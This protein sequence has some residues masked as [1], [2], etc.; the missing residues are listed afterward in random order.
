M[1]QLLKEEI[2]RKR[3][4]SI[5][6]L[7]AVLS[8]ITHID[9]SIDALLKAANPLLVS[10][11][12]EENKTIRDALDNIKEKQGFFEEAKKRVERKRKRFQ[13]GTINI[14]ICGLMK[15]GK[16]T[17][18]KQLTG[19]DF[20]PTMDEKCTAVSTA[21]FYE[22]TPSPSAELE[23]FTE[24]EYVERVIN[25]DLED[26]KLPKVTSLSEFARTTIPDSDAFHERDIVN[27]LKNLKAYRA[28]IEKKL[29]M[30]VQ[31]VND[32]SQLKQLIAYPSEK[33]NDTYAINRQNAIIS[34]IKSCK[35][36]CQ[37]PTGMS[38]LVILDT[39]GVDD[40]NP[41]VV[42]DTIR[43]LE[44]DTD[45]L[46]VMARP[47]NK[48][49]ITKDFEKM[50]MAFEGL[51]DE[52]SLN[53]KM[54]FVLNWHES[55][56]PDKS[57]VQVFQKKLIERGVPKRVFCE[58]VDCSKKDSISVV[59]NKINSQLEQKL[60]SQDNEVIKKFK[61][62]LTNTSNQIWQSLKSIEKTRVVDPA[63]IGDEA[64]K[65]FMRWFE[66][67][68]ETK[69]FIEKLRIGL[70][71]AVREFK[72]QNNTLESQKVKVKDVIKELHEKLKN[73]IPKDA[74]EIKRKG[75]EKGM[76]GAFELYLDE[77][78][79]IATDYIDKICVIGQEFAP[80]IQ[81]ILAKIFQDAGLNPIM[82]GATERDK[83]QSIIDQLPNGS[84]LSLICQRALNL[85]EQL[86]YIIRHKLRPIINLF[87]PF[88]WENNVAWKDFQ[89]AV[90]VLPKEELSKYIVPLDKFQWPHP[91][92]PK[93][94]TVLTD[95]VSGAMLLL[96]GNQ[97]SEIN[98]IA[99]DILEYFRLILGIKEEKDIR[100]TLLPLKAY[101]VPEIE[102]MM[103]SSENIR[104]FKVAV[105]SL[106]TLCN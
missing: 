3:Q 37:F 49:E 62:E 87:N 43:T 83:L 59:M 10:M 45:V 71:K 57:N 7:D 8:K 9:T 5:P 41:K 102:E 80:I 61:D 95:N 14:S 75:V 25:L 101:F 31:F 73:A 30:P 65:K 92:E 84:D 2:V 74:D 42:K 6:D 50:W 19:V 72:V 56:D 91:N 4:Q 99:I 67:D 96:I 36:F 64:T 35:I 1:A 40:T 94:F 20:L 24:K 88:A 89:S 68:G 18:I 98:N 81:D 13:N 21:I 105:E 104:Q 39:A 58:P 11:D 90:S 103:K 28:E 16:T 46:L 69:G 26:L 86:Y 33:S 12:G 79:L 29:G 53:E 23:Y 34:T 100:N 93:D 82:K 48:P 55:V 106:K 47:V 44:E 66:G 15:A 97:S 17:F 52:I 51:S 70:D 22:D 77:M 54:I 63:I 38:D 27:R 78:Y 85:D 76:A 32:V 60:A